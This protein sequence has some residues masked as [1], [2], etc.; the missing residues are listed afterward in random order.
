[1]LIAALIVLNT[2]LGRRP[3][4][5][6]RE[7]HVYTSLG[8]APVHV[9]MLFLAEAAALGT[10]G[11]SSSATSLARAL[12]QFSPTFQLMPGVDLNYSSLGR[13]SS[14]MGLVLSVVMAHSAMRGLLAMASRLA[15][16]SLQR[17]WKLP[18][19][20]GD[21]LVV[22]LP[23]TVNE[24]AARGVCVFLEE[25][26]TSIT[27]KTGSGRFTSDNLQPFITPSTIGATPSAA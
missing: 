10:L 22:D 15:A 4:E 5:R 2:M 21:L 6:T 9:A 23:F 8:L 20:R 13:P 24:A 11:G 16:P 26:F 7:I 25:Y 12:P 14:T 18:A 17:A 27:C 3:G 19:P 1:M